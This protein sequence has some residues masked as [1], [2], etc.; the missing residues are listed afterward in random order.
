MTNIY[1]YQD[2]ETTTMVDHGFDGIDSE[3]PATTTI[4]K[5]EDLHHASS[6][7]NVKK[8]MGATGALVLMVFA[9]VAVSSS[10]LRANHHRENEMEEQDQELLRSVDLVGS[11]RD[12]VAAPACTFEECY[13]SNC[14]WQLAPYTCLFMNGGPHGGCSP[15]P[16]VV[17]ETCTQQC[18]LSG[19]DDQEPPAN[20]KSCD[21]PCDDA[22]WCN[23]VGERL[24]GSAAPF[25]CTVGSA[26]FG[27][28]DDKYTWTFKTSIPT[29]SAC[30]NADK[31]A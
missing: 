7:W 27:C 17:P 15:T 8:W 9:L 11:S 29:C 21:V 4:T 18:D 10:S 28:S 19:C 26:A 3:P 2:T 12:E 5:V 22:E 1:S 30:C 31:C 20:V 24:C 13:G 16:W 25:Q 14:N 6:L 23:A